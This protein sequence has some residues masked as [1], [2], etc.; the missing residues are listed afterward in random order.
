MPLFTLSFGPIPKILTQVSKPVHI[1]LKK[2]LSCWTTTI[3]SSHLTMLLKFWSKAS[4]KKLRNLRMSLRKNP[5]WFQSWVRGLGSLQKFADTNSNKLRAATTRQEN[6]SIFA[7]HE[8]IPN[9]QRSL[10]HQT[11]VL[12]F[13][14]LFSSTHTLTAVLLDIR[15]GD[16]DC[17]STVQ[18]Q[19]CLLLTVSFLL[20]FLLFFILFYS[21]NISSFFVKAN[22]SGTIIPILTSHYGKTCLTTVAG[23][24]TNYNVTL[25]YDNRTLN[26]TAS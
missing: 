16:P 1:M 8:E 14:K 15:N 17:L 7:W 23:L 11:S 10:S 20:L 19:V 24:I 26:I 3:S 9:G 13:F 5:Q 25:G 18:Q 2:S 21:V 6:T 22:L 12:N 4:L